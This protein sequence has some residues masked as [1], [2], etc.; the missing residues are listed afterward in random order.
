MNFRFKNTIAVA[1][2]AAILF[3]CEREKSEDKQP[4]RIVE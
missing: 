1:L 2:L 4:E 3:S